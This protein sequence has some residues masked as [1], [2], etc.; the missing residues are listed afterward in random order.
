[1]EIRESKIESVKEY[2]RSVDSCVEPRSEQDRTVFSIIDELREEAVAVGDQENAKHIWCL[3]QILKIQH[4]YLSAY[5][6]MKED[7]FYDAWCMLENIEVGLNSL[8]KHYDLSLDEYRICFIDI[9]TQEFQELF[10]Y[11]LYVSPGMI[12]LNKTCSI[13]GAKVSIRRSCGHEVGGIYD[14][15]MCHR[16]IH[17]IKPIELSLVTDPV[18]KSSVVFIGGSSN[19]S[20]GEND[21]YDYSVV[22]YAIGGLKS[23]FD[24]WYSTITKVRHPHSYFSK[25]GRNDPCPCSSRKKYKKCCLKESGVLRPHREFHF[26]TPPPATLP[27]IVYPY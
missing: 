4:H 2:L 17:D 23:P 15:K 14:G 16:V 25:V 9:H 22:K 20:I 8:G 13:C 5:Q 24:A 3:E 18:Q 1:M 11:T 12:A 10:P 6:M 19:G 21:R 7:S 26:S 27:E